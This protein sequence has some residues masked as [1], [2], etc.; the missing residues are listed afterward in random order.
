MFQYLFPGEKALERLLFLCDAL[1]YPFHNV[2][3]TI[4]TDWLD[5]KGFIEMLSRK[6]GLCVPPL[7]FLTLEPKYIQYLGVL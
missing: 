6:G 5:I 3:V 2:H 7:L 4:S 1:R